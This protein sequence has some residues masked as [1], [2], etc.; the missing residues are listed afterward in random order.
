MGQTGYLTTRTPRYESFSKDVYHFESSFSY[1]E[2]M[3]QYF[4]Q[5]Q[6]LVIVPVVTLHN[7][8][9]QEAKKD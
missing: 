8:I 1:I 4:L 6:V 3:V 2:E 7:Y 9:R 5:T